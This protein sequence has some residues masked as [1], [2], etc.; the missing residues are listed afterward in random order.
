MSCPGAVSGWSW[1]WSTTTL[2][3]G[4]RGGSRSV[5]IKAMQPLKYGIGCVMLAFL[6]IG[7]AAPALLDGSCP[8]EVLDDLIHREFLCT[9]I[10]AAFGAWIGWRRREHRQLCT[11]MR[12]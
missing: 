2:I 8:Q 3:E 9:F 6:V 12:E 1:A 11:T 5:M 4:P 10:A 7:L